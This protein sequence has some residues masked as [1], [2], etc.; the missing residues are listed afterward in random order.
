MLAEQGYLL[1]E[2]DRRLK[3]MIRIGVVHAVDPAKAKVQVQI[4]QNTTDW[5]PW[6]AVAGMIKTWNPPVVGEQVLVLSPGGDFEQSVVVPS[7]YY[8]AFKAPSNDPAE[9]CIAL[10]EESRVTWDAEKQQL[11][12]T[13]ADTGILECSVGDSVLRCDKDAMRL[14]NSDAIVR[15]EDGRV[16]LQSGNQQ[17][18]LG[19][20][21][22]CVETPN[23]SI[24]SADS[25]ITFQAGGQ[26]LELTPQG[27]FLNG[28]PLGGL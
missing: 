18:N 2:L 15:L 14:E 25:V 28:M 10:S 21:G 3:Q 20:D 11:Q 6:L 12:V 27:L 8:T 4:G 5:R 17:V 26:T 1:S 7:L 23:T 22:V 19:P 13:L 16:A 24:T 9:H